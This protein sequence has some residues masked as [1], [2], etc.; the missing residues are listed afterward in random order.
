MVTLNDIARDAQ[1]L[2]QEQGWA[3]KS[4]EERFVYL[5]GEVGELAQAISRL[6]LGSGVD[7]DSERIEARADVGA[8]MY[9]VI[10]NV[11][12]LANILS[13]DLDAAAATKAEFNRRRI[14]R[15]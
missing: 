5:V 14:S 13:I 6:R 9:D 8:E 2:R 11:C 4:P 3:P 12:D 7:G 10:W 1:R 15:P